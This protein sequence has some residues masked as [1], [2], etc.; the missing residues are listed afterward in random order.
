MSSSSSTSPLVKIAPTTVFKIGK[1]QVPI[2][3]CADK[4]IL[5]I[6]EIY[7]KKVGTWIWAEIHSKLQYKIFSALGIRKYGEIYNKI[8]KML[9]LNLNIDIG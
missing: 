1:L 6:I 5:K 8:R 4:L 2:R 9:L 7:E 3:K